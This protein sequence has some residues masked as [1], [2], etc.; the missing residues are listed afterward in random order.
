MVMFRHI[1]A[2][3]TTCFENGG[4]DLELIYLSLIKTI[5]NVLSSRFSVDV[6]LDLRLSSVSTE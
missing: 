5:K 6:K 1:H 4:Q 3:L 2:T